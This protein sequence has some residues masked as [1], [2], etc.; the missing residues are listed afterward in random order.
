MGKASMGKDELLANVTTQVATVLRD[1]NVSSMHIL[2][3]LKIAFARTGTQERVVEGVQAALPPDPAAVVK[4][5]AA[6]EA[7]EKGLRAGPAGL[8]LS[9]IVHKALESVIRS[10]QDYDLMGNDVITAVRTGIMMSDMPKPLREMHDFTASVV[11]A[12]MGGASHEEVLMAVRRGME[13][14]HNRHMRMSGKPTA[15][16]KEV[17]WQ[18]GVKKQTGGQGWGPTH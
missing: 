12:R 7:V 17:G 2:D 8:E 11:D 15:P 1:D 13:E 5:E 14:L 16:E 18:G 9:G 4:P 3:A 6:R 10:N